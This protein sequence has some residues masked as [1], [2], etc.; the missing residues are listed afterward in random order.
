MFKHQRTLPF[1]QPH[2]I[3][4]LETQR[5]LLLSFIMVSYT[6]HPFSRLLTEL[7]LKIWEAACFPSQQHHKALHYF[8]LLD[9]DDYSTKVCQM[10]YETQDPDSDHCSNSAYPSVY[11]WD[12]GLWTAC[13]ESREVIL[14]HLQLMIRSRSGWNSRGQFLASL[15]RK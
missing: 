1:S 4:L 7:R 15:A 6:F 13:K 9:V 8:K 3:L 11:I 10:K 12:A 5:H 14:R 2:P